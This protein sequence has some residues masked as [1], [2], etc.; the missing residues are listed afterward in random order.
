MEVLTSVDDKLDCWKSLFTSVVDI[1]FPL[2]SVR[3]RNHS[4][5]WINDK[6]VKL[7]RSR[8]YFRTKFRRTKCLSEWN[9][10]KLLKKAVIKELRRAKAAYFAD[11]G[12]TISGN[13]CKGWNLLNSVVRPKQKDHNLLA[14]LSLLLVSLSLI[15]LIL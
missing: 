12:R 1:H 14:L 2:C 6:V 11:I 7:M 3:L 5:K 10:F 4:L 9:K 15:L 8:N 13:P